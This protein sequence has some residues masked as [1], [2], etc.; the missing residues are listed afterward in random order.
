MQFGLSNAPGTFLRTMDVISL[1]V[2]W[3]VALVYFVDIITLLRAADKNIKHVRAEM[4]L[5]HIAGVT[6]YLK[7]ASSLRRKLT[8]WNT[9]YAPVNWNSLLT[10]RTQYALNCHD[11]EQNWSY[12]WIYAM[13]TVAS[14]PNLHEML[15]HASPSWNGGAQTI[16]H[17]IDWGNGRPIGIAAEPHSCPRPCITSQRGLLSVRLWR[18]QQTNSLCSD[19][20]SAGSGEKTT[21]ILSQTLKGHRIVLHHHAS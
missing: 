18:V 11:Q 14:F 13:H 21:G 16:G 15:P 19:A 3:E 2:K 20:G 4:L 6:L 10:S 17:L 5:L 7:S 9:W 8:T 12:S 1:P